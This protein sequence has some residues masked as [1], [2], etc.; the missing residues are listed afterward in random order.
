MRGGTLNALDCPNTA[1]LVKKR[2]PVEPGLM[3]PAFDLVFLTWLRV[4]RTDEVRTPTVEP[5]TISSILGALEKWS[6]IP[7][8][9]ILVEG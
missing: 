3:F 7:A 8:T 4:R 9:Y 1:R 6:I 5:Q 2:G